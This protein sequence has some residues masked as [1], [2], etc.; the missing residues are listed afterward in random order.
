MLDHVKTK[1]MCKH[2]VEKLPFVSDQYKTQQIFDKA[3]LENDGTLQS[4]P[5][6]YRNQYMC[7]KALDNYPH[8]FKF[9]PSCYITQKMCDKAVN[10]HHSRI[11]H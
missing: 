3:I 7:D 10:T 4:V 6:Y 11:Q 5:D 1:N 9:V 8:K 2:A